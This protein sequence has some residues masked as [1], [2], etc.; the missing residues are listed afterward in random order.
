MT[1]YLRKCCKGEGEVIIIPHLIII[2]AIVINSKVIQSVESIDYRMILG[3]I[4]G[5]NL[6]ALRSKE[7]GSGSV[8]SSNYSGNF[9]WNY[10]E[11]KRAGSKTG[12][13]LNTGNSLK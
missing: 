7:P 2:M 4:G 8:S 13:L 10:E 11:F 9:F 12:N 1:E 6:S 3:M 5:M